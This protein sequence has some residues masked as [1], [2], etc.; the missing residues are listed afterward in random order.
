MVADV[1]FRVPSGDTMLSNFDSELEKA[2]TRVP[3]LF[4]L[5]QQ[6]SSLN[7]P[8]SVGVGHGF[9]CYCCCFLSATFPQKKAENDF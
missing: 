4:E 1:I 3:K 2:S 5:S 7:S 6:W 9:F 8:N